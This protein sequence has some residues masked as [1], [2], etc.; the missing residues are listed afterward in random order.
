MHIVVFGAGRVGKA[1]VRIL[2]ERKHKVTVV[3]ADRAICDEV[4]GETNASVICGDVSDPK[5]M[6]ELKLDRADFVF[7]VTGSEE[8]NFL[9]SMYA[10]HMN[11]KKVISRASEEKYSQ[12]MGKLGVEPLIPEQT[13]ARELAN[14]VLNPLIS[15]MLDPSFSGVEMFEKEVAADMKN[16]TVADVSK[17]QNI[18]IVSV[19][20][21][22]KF[23]LPSPEFV[24][25]EGMTVVV[26]RHNV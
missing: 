25:K 8:T 19:Y 7:A 2:E 22:G 16:K 3:D 10:K 21:E 20:H 18:G 26:V 1:L 12:L 23:V 17:K 13:L 15:R 5:L 14:M 6:E 24:L 4:A 9:V 11:A